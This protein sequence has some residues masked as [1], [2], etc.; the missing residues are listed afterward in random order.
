M[1]TSK[2]PEPILAALELARAAGLAKAARQFPEDVAAAVRSAA[3]ARDALGAPA[4]AAA[5]PWPP[6]RMR[7]LP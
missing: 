2:S 6:M 5:E 4:Q 1:A 3:Q 7:S